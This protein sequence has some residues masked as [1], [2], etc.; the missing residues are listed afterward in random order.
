[1]PPLEGP[2]VVLWC[3]RWPTKTLTGPASSLMGTATVMDRFGLRRTSWTPAS[4]FM[5]RA[6]SSSCSSADCH[7]VVLT[8][9]AS[10]TAG[11]ERIGG[12]DARASSDG[13]AVIGPWVQGLAQL[14][15]R[16]RTTRRPLAD[17]DLVDQREHDR[18]A[19]SS[20][21]VELR[22][23]NLSIEHA[24]VLDEDLDL[25]VVASPRDLDV[26]AVRV[27]DGVHARF[28]HR[29]HQVVGDRLLEPG[30]RGLRTN[31]VPDLRQ[32]CGMRAE[33]SIHRQHAHGHVLSPSSGESVRG[34]DVL[35][36]LP[37][38]MDRNR[39]PLRFQA[40]RSMSGVTS[41]ATGSDAKT[42]PRET[43]P[44]SAATSRPVSTSVHVDGAE[45]GS[46]SASVPHTFVP[47]GKRPEVVRLAVRRG[48]ATI[49]HMRRKRRA[50]A[51]TCSA[52]SPLA[53]SGTYEPRSNSSAWRRRTR[54]AERVTWS[55]IRPFLHERRSS[56]IAR[57]A[58]LASGAPSSSGPSPR[59]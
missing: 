31:E 47:S 8:P 29:E 1:M 57:A 12:S 56:A 55:L 6:A 7:A 26:R 14:Y 52:R 45:R 35:P 2:R 38:G 15:L 28:R 51:T 37:C 39:V 49:A 33:G 19:P 25:P 32:S 23:R 16:S 20:R 21:P 22:H 41:N 40:M 11:P 9:L 17:R 24:L 59:S 18:D 53:C 44:S 5:S 13:R 43:S 36:H 27:D 30:R 48:A 10:V 3:T 50:N 58:P 34:P 42:A 54:N 46:R 4:R